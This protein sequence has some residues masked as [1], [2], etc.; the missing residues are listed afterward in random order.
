M[1]R[2]VD[3]AAA[4]VVVYL[5]APGDGWPV[6]VGDDP[7]FECSGRWART[8]ARLSWGVCRPDLRNTIAAGDVMVFIA[9]DRM[10]DRRPARYQLAGWATA[11]RIVSQLDIWQH[12]ELAV[13][14]HYRNLLIRPAED[15]RGFIHHETQHPGHPDW[16]WR[17]ARH[18]RRGPPKTAWITAG[19]LQAI[20][21]DGVFHVGRRPEQVAANYILFSAGLEELSS[22]PIRPLSPSP[23]HP[24]S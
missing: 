19:A 7:A 11:E 2:A 20:P 14:G 9:A 13:Y 6:D 24:D 12:E 10:S 17:L 22:C 5:R 16:L 4:Y 15:G 1:L 21:S 8:G 23:R 18:T 3:P